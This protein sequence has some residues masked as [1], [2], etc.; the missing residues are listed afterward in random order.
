MNTRLT[1]VPL[2]QVLG[3]EIKCSCGME[4]IVSTPLEEL[5]PNCPSCKR[6][7]GAMAVA[8]AN[9]YAYAKDHR[10]AFRIKQT[11]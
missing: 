3:I 6:S 9:L 8:I 5:S 1:V 4:W 11:E 2:D 7:V 10:V